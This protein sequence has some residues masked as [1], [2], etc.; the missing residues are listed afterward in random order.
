MA[1]NWPRASSFRNK[2]ADLAHRL[3]RAGPSRQAKGKQAAR[4]YSGLCLA[5][6][7][8]GCSSGPSNPSDDSRYLQGTLVPQIE[9]WA[10]GNSA[11]MN[12][13]QILAAK[14]YDNICVVPDYNPVAA[15]EVEVGHLNTY[16]GTRGAMVPEGSI[17]IVAT[18]G[19]TAHVAFISQGSLILY[20]EPRRCRRAATAIIRRVPPGSITPQYTPRGSLEGE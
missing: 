11:T 13:A 1:N 12:L 14:A 16:H 2:S 8:I 5:L 20:G 18:H 3:N 9:R 17:A 7:L 6:G 10:Q 15:I 4:T 19:D